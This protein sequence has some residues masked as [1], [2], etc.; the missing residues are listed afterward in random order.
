M[1][2]IF[3]FFTVLLILAAAQAPL[4]AAQEWKA[5]VAKVLITPEGSLWQA[6]FAARTRP[7]EGTLQPLYAKA[8]ALE[9]QAGNHTVLITADLLGFTAEMSR[10]ISQRAQEKYGLP[11]DRLLFNASHTHGGPIVGRMLAVAYPLDRRQWEDVAEY[12]RRLEDKILALI[13]A[14]LADLAPARL[15]AGKTQAMFAANRRVPTENGYQ[16]GV[17]RL[18]PVDHNVPF[19]AVDDSRGQLRGIVFSYACHNTTVPAQEYRF[20][21]DWAGYSQAWLEETYPDATAFFLNGCGADANAYPRGSVEWA[22]RHGE[23]LARAVHE[24]LTGPLEAVHGPVKSTLEEISLAFATPPSRRELE[25]RLQGGN[26]YE[27]RHARE[28]LEILDEKG[29]IP[30]NYPYFLQVWQFGPDFTLVALAGEVVVDYALRLK[31][32]LGPGTIWVA[33][34]SNDVSAYIPSRRILEEGGYEGGG[35][36][37]YY[38]QPGPFTISVEATIINK[39]RQ[40][41]KRLRR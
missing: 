38:V 7:S 32:E 27:R 39:V 1:P 5:G 9:D 29:A 35:A 30:T 25:V 10:N 34:Y 36:M 21:G 11:R 6:G 19:L 37:L 4:A 8:L 31:K 41:V 3:R 40:M 26:V 15:S 20:H 13:G 22:S 24:A 16:G 18:G 14:A 17:N 33:G 2:A 12:T 28:M 23:T